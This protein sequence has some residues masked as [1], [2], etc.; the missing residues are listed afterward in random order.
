MAQL[1]RP[2]MPRLGAT[3]TVLGYLGGLGFFG[4]HA[5][6]VIDAAAAGRPD[7]DAMVSLIESAQNSALA[8]LIVVPFMLGLL[9][10]VLLASIGM[11]RTRVVHWWIPATLLL[12]LVLDFGP[13]GTGPVDPHWLFLAAS[14]GLAVTIARRTDREWWTGAEKAEN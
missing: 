8:L 4:I 7:R 2:R 5:V 10:A 9:G 1:V 13:L 14:V 12:F 6:S 11:L 3:A